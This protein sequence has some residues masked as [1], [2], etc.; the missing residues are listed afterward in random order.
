MDV[1]LKTPARHCAVTGQ[2]FAPGDRRVCLLV[3]NADGDLERWDVQPEAVEQFA[4]L[5]V[6]LCR[7]VHTVRD[8]AEASKQKRQ[9]LQTVEDLFLALCGEPD[10]LSGL[11]DEDLPVSDAGAEERAT[12]KY[13]LAL[14]LERKRVLKPHDAEH[15]W[16]VR[17]KKAYAVE[18]I[19][20]EPERVAAVQAQLTLLV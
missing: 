6:I 15:Y 13:L 16:H 8:P 12:L 9:Q 18:P 4:P 20:L 14:Q 7:W 3:R 10:M 19:E 5:G 1:S 2:S 17:R 11:D